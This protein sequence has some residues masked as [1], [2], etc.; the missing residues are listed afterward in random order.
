V[1]TKKKL[2][3]LLKRLLLK[4]RLRWKRLRWKLLRWTLL[5][6]LLLP[7]LMLLPLLL[8]LLLPLLLLLLHLLPSNFWLRSE[9]P[10][11]WPVFLRLQKTIKSCRSL[12]QAG[13]GLGAGKAD[14]AWAVVRTEIE[15]CGY[16]DTRWL[17]NWVTNAWLW[18]LDRL[19]SA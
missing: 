10:A 9:K 13:Q 1:A 14:M 7:R 4:H 8:M 11:F 5:L 2:L 17:S 16:S 19:Q 18:G 12:G 15:S 3:L 6:M